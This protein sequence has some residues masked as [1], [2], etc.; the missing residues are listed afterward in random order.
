LQAFLRLFIVVEI[1]F[2]PLAGAVE[3]VDE[4]PEQV[5]EIGFNAGVDQS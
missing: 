4:V 1:A 2:D 3:D 5:F